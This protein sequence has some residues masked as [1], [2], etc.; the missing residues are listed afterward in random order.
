MSDAFELVGS[1]EKQFQDILSAAG[2]PDFC[3]LRYVCERDE[4]VSVRQ[5]VPEPVQRSE[6][7]GVMITVMHN[8]GL[9]YTATCDLTVGG[10]Q[11]AA[12][13]A[14]QFAESTAGRSV[15]DF[16]KI[17]MPASCGEYAGP[18]EKPWAS[19]A[20]NEKFDRLRSACAALRINERIVDW[21]A[22]VWGT[23]VDMLLLTSTGGRLVQRLQYIAPT[24]SATANQGAETQT[25]SLGMNAA[26][27]ILNVLGLPHH[28]PRRV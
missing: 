3:S 26:L 13:R 22:S 23:D 1:L 7:A 11:T 20:L 21:E 27:H 17:D 19:M 4:M 28:Q 12:K 8:G 9:G 5:D 6:D 10:L 25:R 24:L 18:V 2:A 16:S 14:R 15:T